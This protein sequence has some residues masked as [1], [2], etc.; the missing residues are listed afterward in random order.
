MDARAAQPPAPPVLVRVSDTGQL[1][2]AIP[3]IL[4]FRPAESVVLLSLAGE[5]GTRLGLTVRADIPP[6]EHGRGLARDLA[7]KLLTGR[8]SGV[9]AVVV[10]DDPDEGAA[11]PHLGLVHDLR[12]VFS[13]CTLPVFDALLLRDGRWWSYDCPGPCCAPGA[14]T[15]LPAGVSEME[16]ASVAAGVVVEPDRRALTERIARTTGP[17]AAAMQAVADRAGDRH[18]RARLAD[19]AGT[20]RRSWT[21]I[22]QAVARCRAGAASVPLTDR[23]IARVVW[24]LADVRVRDRAMG[25][26]LDD[27]AAAVEVL[28]TEC[29]RR[30]PA[31]LD[32]APAT[33]LAVS[34]WLRGDG[35]MAG[36]AL[37][38]ALESRP[39]YT[40]ARLLS[41]G[42]AACLRPDDLRTMI[43]QAL[44]DLDEAS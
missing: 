44:A 42:L 28:W 11:L 23:E 20:A 33:L 5:S 40:L 41:D 6:A 34:A 15:P 2:A 13:T 29:T 10:S 43:R 30:A 3:H 21:L 4:G 38:R 14:G 39:T 27:D 37:D 1:V 36:V 18:A 8:P 24:G 19:E 35:A 25:L 22:L 7:A 9:V 26:A 12:A 16:A 32:A 17:D 31:P